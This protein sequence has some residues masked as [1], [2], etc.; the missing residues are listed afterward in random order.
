MEVEV[1]HQLCGAIGVSLA[2]MILV[3]LPFAFV[4]AMFD[5]R[6]RD[7]EIIAREHDRCKNAVRMVARRNAA[8]PAAWNALMDAVDEIHELPTNERRGQ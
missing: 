8:K 7:R 2:A 6:K 1:L 4:M 5:R 3:I